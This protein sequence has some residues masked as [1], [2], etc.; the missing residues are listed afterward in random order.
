MSHVTIGR[1]GRALAVRLPGEVVRTIGLHDGDRVAVEI[2]EGDIVIRPVE[3]RV[4]L[5]KLFEGKSAEEWRAAYAGAFDWGP[6]I[7]R[8]AVAE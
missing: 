5:D 4:A 8:E 1:W 3:P 7:G 6:D 2:V